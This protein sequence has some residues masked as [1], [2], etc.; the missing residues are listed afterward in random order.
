MQRHCN[1]KL[2]LTMYECSGV[3]RADEE[4]GD[5]C[6]G[7]ERGHSKPETDQC[8]KYAEQKCRVPKLLL[9]EGEVNS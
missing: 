4:E 2:A 1:A 8:M 3:K 7:S 9:Q 5:S 6:S